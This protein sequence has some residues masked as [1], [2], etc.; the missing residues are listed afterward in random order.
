MLLEYNL[1]K[2]ESLF[3][4][5]NKHSVHHLISQGNTSSTNRSSPT[6]PPRSFHHL[7]IHNKVTDSHSTL[8]NGSV[9]GGDSS[10]LL[11]SRLDSSVPRPS[12]IQHTPS[13]LSLHPKDSKMNNHKRPYPFVSSLFNSPPYIPLP[14]PPPAHSNKQTPAASA[15]NSPSESKQPR[16]ATPLA[17]PLAHQT[18]DK[19]QPPLN[20]IDVDHPADFTYRR[21]ELFPLSFQTPSR[22]SGGDAPLNLSVKKP[23]ERS[24]RSSHQRSTPLSVHG[25]SSR[26]YHQVQI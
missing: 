15:Y 18:P 14:T 16:L 8:I 20:I 21:P 5:D 3:S 25:T 6:L 24:E 7:T 11:S 10:D 17:A 4:L 12:V 19:A 13:G 1:P 26:S 2:N 23:S 9:H 22:S